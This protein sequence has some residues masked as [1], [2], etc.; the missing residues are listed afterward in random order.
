MRGEQHVR[1]FI[2]LFTLAAMPCFAN[3]FQPWVERFACGNASYAV[4]SSCKASGQPDT[5]NECRS[6]T[7]EVVHGNSGRKAALPELPKS[8]AAAIKRVGGEIKNLFLVDQ[9]CADVGGT[10][11]EIFYYSIGGGSAPYAGA[12]AVYDEV[13]KL[14]E[15]RDPRMHKAMAYPFEKLKPVRSIMPD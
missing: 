5:L 9:G 6:Q 2:G 8:T 1:W 12:Y 13:G 4:T 3:D 7:M 11:V 14:L 15:E 10:K